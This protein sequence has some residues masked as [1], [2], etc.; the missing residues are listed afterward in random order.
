VDETPHERIA[1]AVARQ[2]RSQEV[3]REEA[4]RLAQQRADEREK[5]QDS[6]DGAGA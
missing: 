1:S 5:E 2:Q 3:I 6:G 4:D